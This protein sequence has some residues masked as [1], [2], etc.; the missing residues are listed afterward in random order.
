MPSFFTYIIGKSTIPIM[1]T[2]SEYGREIVTTR[3]SMRDDF[4]ASPLSAPTNLISAAQIPTR[5]NFQILETLD[6]EASLST[7]F[8]AS[9]LTVGFKSDASHDCVCLPFSVS[10][11]EWT[12]TGYIRSL[13]LLQARISDDHIVERWHLLTVS[14]SEEPV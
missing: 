14:M 6:A 1:T 5:S 10:A 9:A 12:F 3:K 11:V 13:S 8:G 2:S 7:I 4:Y